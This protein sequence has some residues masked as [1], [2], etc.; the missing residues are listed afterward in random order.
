[1]AFD[2]QRLLDLTEES[3]DLQADAMRDSRRLLPDLRELGRSRKGRP[4]DLDKVR[5]FNSERR[6]VL[7][8]GGMGM[9]ALAAKG[10][11]GT[12]FGTTLASIVATPASAQADPDVSILQTAASLENLAVAAYGAALE[13]PFLA[14][15]AGPAAPVLNAFAMTT[16]E[17]HAEH[18]AGFNA[19][20]EALGGEPQDQPNPEFLPAVEEAMLTDAIAVVELASTLEEVPADTYLQNVPTLMHSESKALMGSVMGVEVQHL[21]TLRA[22]GALLGAG[23][24]ELITPDPPVD[25]A[26]LPEA[27]GSVAFP[28]AFPEPDMAADPASGAVA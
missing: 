15:D 25:A 16:M 26:A 28:M 4:V 19:Q 14:P 24:V 27:A 9:G 10:L 1:M 8:N 22:V 21:A 11:I 6:R 7:R 17:Q 2:T 23:A 13:L 20:A 18:G 3:Q 12:A 5:A